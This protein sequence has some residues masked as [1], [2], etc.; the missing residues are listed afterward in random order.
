R[1]APDTI[2]VAA[3]PPLTRQQ[4]APCVAPGRNVFTIAGVTPNADV[5]LFWSTSGAQ[6]AVIARVSKVQSGLNSPL[7]LAK[8]KSSSST[9][10]LTVSLNSSLAGRTIRLQAV[11][12]GNCAASN[13]VTR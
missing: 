2:P 13:V 7:M 4:P 10:R 8:G 11:D 5:F 9:L 12:S 1:T 6:S 3:P